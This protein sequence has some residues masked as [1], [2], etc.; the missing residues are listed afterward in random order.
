MELALLPILFSGSPSAI[1]INMPLGLHAVLAAA[2]QPVG[3]YTTSFLRTRGRQLVA[4]DERMTEQAGF[5][6][7]STGLKP[8]PSYC[9]TR[10]G[11]QGR[12]VRRSD[13]KAQS[14]CPSIAAIDP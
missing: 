4:D 13:G 12:M 9:A 5:D 8:F 7:G 11:L 14:I 2:F 10:N 1:L 3:G 6:P